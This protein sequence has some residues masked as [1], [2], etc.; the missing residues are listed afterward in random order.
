MRVSALLNSFRARLLL[1]L[2][3]LLGL[4]LGVQYYLNLR[5]V[6]SNA[7]LIVEQEQA[8][9]AGVALGVNSISSTKYLD[10]I[11]SNL[12]DPDIDEKTGRVKNVLVVDSEGLVQDSLVGDYSPRENGDITTIK[13][14]HPG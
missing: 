1:L 5:A 10:Q 4:T 2:A 12:Q 3:V 11:R 13:P 8:I 14:C 7:H 9:M 6:R